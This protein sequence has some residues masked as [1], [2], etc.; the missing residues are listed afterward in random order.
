ME[1][2]TLGL[3]RF[4]GLVTL[5]EDLRLRWSLNQSF[6]P[7]QELSNDMSHVTWTQVN[8]VDSQI[9]VVGSQ[10]VNLTPGLSFG[11]NLC[12]KSPNGWCKII[13]DIY[14]LIVFQW[15]KE[16]LNRLCF[17]PYNRSLNIWESTGT[18]TPKVGVPLGV[19]GSIPSHFLAFMGACDMIHGFPSWPATLQPL[20][21][22]TIPRLGLR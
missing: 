20:A 11:H 16:L 6:S 8:Q 21:L 9:L 15:Y 18:P 7:C 1:L 12:F 10:I 5:C 2:S 19:W 3:P 17:D 13:L 4:W 14:V 22:V